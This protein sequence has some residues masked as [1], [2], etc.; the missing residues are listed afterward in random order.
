M[1]TRFFCRAL[2]LALFAIGAPVAAQVAPA[3]V[4]VNEFKVDGNTLLS[5]TAIELALA[6]YKGERTFAELKQAALVVQDLYRKAGYGAVIAYLPEQT[7]NGNRAVITVLE[8]RIARITVVGNQRVTSEQVRRSVPALQA[9]RTPHVPQ[10]DAQMQL[11]ND[12]PTRQFALVLEP[13]QQAGE[14]DARISVTEREPTAWTLSA[15]NTG[16]AQTGQLRATIGWRHGALWDRDHQLSLQYQTSPDKPSAVAIFSGNY[17]VPMYELGMRLDAFAAHSNVDGGNTA[18]VVG[19]LQFVGRGNVFGARLSAALP[20]LGELD[21][22]LTLGLERREY[23]NDCAITGLPAGAC[24]AAGESVAVTPLTLEYALQQ[25]G[26]LPMGLSLAL[27][28]NLGLGGR[29]TQAAN[30][31]AVRDGAPRAYSMARVGVFANPSLGGDWRLSARLTGQFTPDALV[32]GEQFG[33]A[34]ANTVRGYAEREVVGDSAWL[35]NI[36]LLGPELRAN[37]GGRLHSLRAVAFA[38]SGRVVNELGTECLAGSSRCALSSLGLGLRASG[39]TWQLRGDLA[40]PLKDGN[41][42]ERHKLKLHVA[43]SMAFE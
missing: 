16:N 13:G 11:A 1:K 24:G 10:L 33:L 31:S 29:Y 39:A 5:A 27:T 7:M 34:G 6:P 38:D 17:S 37:R 18:T 3:R 43:A 8:G 19:A 14:V 9:G 41:R 28:R 30:F 23:L 22:R 35:A 2:A 20:R 12:N 36:E 42:T 32:P 15:D 4:L 21:Q 40:Y 25:G 26:A